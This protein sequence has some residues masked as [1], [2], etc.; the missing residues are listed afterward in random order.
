VDAIVYIVALPAGLIV[1]LAACE[2]AMVL[3]RWLLR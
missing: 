3:G 1:F 2:G